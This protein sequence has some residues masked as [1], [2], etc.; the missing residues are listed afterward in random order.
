MRRHS[1]SLFTYA[2]LIS[3]LVSGLYA[4]NA[5]AVEEVS[6]LIRVIV[7]ASVAKKIG[8]GALGHPVEDV[9]QS[10]VEIPVPGPLPVSVPGLK[11]EVNDPALK[12]YTKNLLGIDLERS[13]DLNLRIMGL[14]V[15]GDVE[16]RTV[17]FTP[18]PR[19]AD[20]V[21]IDADLDLRNIHVEAGKIWIMEHGLTHGTEA[22]R[23]D[24]PIPAD[25]LTLVNSFKQRGVKVRVD[26]GRV[27]PKSVRDG[28]IPVHA[29]GRYEARYFV[30]SKGK[31]EMKL[32]PIAVSHDVERVLNEHYQLKA[33]IVLPPIYWLQDDPSRPGKSVCKKADMSSIQ[34]LFHS[35]LDDIKKVVTSSVNQTLIDTAMDASKDAFTDLQIPVEQNFSEERPQIKFQGPEN[36]M[37]VDATRAE[38]SESENWTASALSTQKSDDAQTPVANKTILPKFLWKFNE[39]IALGSLGAAPSPGNELRLELGDRTTL[40]EKTEAIIQPAPEG[41]FPKQSPEALRVII[42]RE[43]FASKMKLV[44]SLR[45]EQAKLLPPGI[46]LDETGIRVNAV[47]GGRLSFTAPIDIHLKD[48]V[49]QS[50]IGGLLE[51]IETTTGGTDGVYRI[52]VQVNLVPQIIG[53]GASRVLRL[54]FTLR[55]DLFETEF[56]DRSNLNEASK[57]FLNELTKHR[58]LLPKLKELAETVRSHPVDLNLADIEAKAPI[59]LD[60]I[61]LN[62]QGSL[63]VDVSVSD[64][65]GWM[66]N[67]KA[68]AAAEAAKAATNANGAKP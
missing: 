66:A 17:K 6:S 31:R 67:N 55:E 28:T 2:L 11:I 34:A 19:E 8:Q 60:R 22:G 21:F 23:H 18:D 47:A 7:P 36:R 13:F 53:T 5:S 63:A 42:N 68:A 3:P 51:K 59:H 43:F 44:S 14:K 33:D 15:F 26:H 46:V 27:I 49:K 32:A 30:N 54:Q 41:K 39:E 61:T 20:H 50:W 65:R 40:D 58:F 29:H 56:G 35:M 37:A 16:I 12:I 45:D 48:V 38:R 57:I 25:A 62:D 64:F 24:C 9:K 1:R 10:H 4:E 52:P